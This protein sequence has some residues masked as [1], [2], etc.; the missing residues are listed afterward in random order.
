MSVLNPFF[1]S[2]NDDTESLWE[3]CKNSE[4]MV[5]INRAIKSPQ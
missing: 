2:F 4:I 3:N 5:K 1:V